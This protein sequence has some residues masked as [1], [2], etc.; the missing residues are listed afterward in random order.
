[1]SMVL[2]VIEN[3]VVSVVVML[4]VFSLVVGLRISSFIFNDL[5][6]VVVSCVGCGLCVSS[7]YVSSVIISGCV[8]MI[9]VVMLFGRCCVVINNS[10][11]NMLMFVS[12]RKSSGNSLL[13]VGRLGLSSI[14]SMLVGSVCSVLIS[15]GWFIGSVC[16]KMRYVVFYSMGVKVVV[17]IVVRWLNGMRNFYVM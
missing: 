14:S 15:N 1:M 4:I 10:V 12:L 3:V 6:S 13:C 16:V 17:N 8:D 2:I 5:V 11:K 7:G 9:V